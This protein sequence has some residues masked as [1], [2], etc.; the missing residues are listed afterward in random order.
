MAYSISDAVQK[1]AGVVAV[2]VCMENLASLPT[3]VSV[4]EVG[5]SINRD[6]QGGRSSNVPPNISHIFD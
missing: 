5:Q 1:P 3:L 4:A 6:F 2:V